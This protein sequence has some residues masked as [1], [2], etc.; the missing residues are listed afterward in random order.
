MKTLRLA[1]G[2]A[3]LL[4]AAGVGVISVDH[5]QNQLATL[6][7]CRAAETG[8]WSEVLTRTEERVG[9]DATGRSA[10]ECRCLAL[11]ATGAGAACVELLEEILA[12][13]RAED[14]SPNPT[15]AVHVIQTWRDAGRG[16]EA[17]AL[18]K[19]A[20]QH[21]PEDPDHYIGKSHV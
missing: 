1:L 14:W 13:P 11:L 16:T 19:R 9:A 15:L 21:Q 8:H 2:I 17:A 7:A 5:V 3:F 20:A 4:A 18:A 10:A 12:D 6:E